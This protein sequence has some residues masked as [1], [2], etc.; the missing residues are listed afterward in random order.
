[1][2]PHRFR[3]VEV[4]GV[5]DAAHHQSGGGPVLREGERGVRISA[6][7]ASEIHAP[8]P[9]SR[10]AFGYC[11]GVH[12][13]SS[14]V[15]IAFVIAEF[16]VITSEN[17]ALARRQART[18][19]RVPYAESPRTRICAAAPTERAVAIAPAIMCPAPFPDPVLPERSR[20]PAI[21]GAQSSVLSTAASGDRPLRSSCLPAILVC[22]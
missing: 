11:T 14:I 19:L 5:F 9:G 6:T 7:S 17:S 1:M 4:A 20:I 2:P 3:S 18:T 15:A 13:F 10:T 21:T 12:A 8:V 16:F 22:P